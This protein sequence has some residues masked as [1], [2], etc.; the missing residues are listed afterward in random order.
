MSLALVS[1]LASPPGE[2]AGDALPPSGGMPL[3]PELAQL[4][5]GRVLKRGGCVGV[6]GG[7]GRTSLLLQL[8]A[9]PIAAG[10]WAAVIGLPAL[11]T[12]A[13]SGL[14]ID[15]D[16]LALVPSPGTAWLE[17]TAA[18]LDAVD[19][20]VLAPPRSARPA[21]ARRLM[22]R[23]RQRHSVLVV[24]NGKWPDS[25]DVVLTAEQSL[26]TGLRPGHGSLR[27]CLLNVAASGRRLN[28]PGRTGL[29][30]AAAR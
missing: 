25:P 23:A 9:A 22:A 4:L 10:G 15:L 17:V 30:T 11:G 28:G 19:I 18:L 5:P 24:I 3:V 14:G 29:L 8:L 21:D 13:A 12:E 16:R 6:A 26:W 1:P 20:V 2:A 7:P 27:S